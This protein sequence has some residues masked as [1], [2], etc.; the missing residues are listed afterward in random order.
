MPMIVA[1]RCQP[2]DGNA[3]LEWRSQAAIAPGDIFIP[4]TPALS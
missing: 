1:S 3:S 4:P 2:P